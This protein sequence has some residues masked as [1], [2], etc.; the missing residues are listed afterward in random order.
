[1]KVLPVSLVTVVALLAYVAYLRPSETHLEFARTRLAVAQ[2]ELATV[3]GR[4]VIEPRLRR[5]HANISKRL[6]RLAPASPSRAEAEFLDDATALAVQTGT[7]I[8]RIL[9]KGTALPLA[10]ASPGAPPR[11]SA[12][13]SDVQGVRLPRSLTVEG[14]FGAVLHFVDGL[15]MVR[16]LV[17]VRRVDLAQTDKLRATIDLDLVVFDAAQLREALL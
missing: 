4:T 7:H 16:T 15:Q 1:M 8:A 11:S 13:D 10:Q 9:A 2:G 14:S 5:E 6:A 12:L 17:H 3:L